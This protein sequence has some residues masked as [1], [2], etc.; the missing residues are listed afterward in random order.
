LRLALPNSCAAE[1]ARR[2]LVVLLLALAVLAL[3]DRAAARAQPVAVGGPGE[4]RLPCVSYAPFRREGHTPFNAALI[5]SPAQIEADLR[6]LRELTGCVRTYGIDHGLDQVPAIARRLGLRVVLGVWIGSDAAANAAQLDRALGL[7][8]E[9]ADV[10]DLLMVGNEVLLRRELSAQALGTLLADAKR[11]SSV[12]IGYADV[13]EFWLRHGAALRD[14]VDVVSVH[15]LPYWEDEPVAIG[16][17]VAHVQAILALVRK[18][19]QAQPVF[20]AE[21]GWP[22]DGRQRGAAVPGRLEQTRFVRDMLALDTRPAARGVPA[23]NLIEGFDQ[24]WKRSLEGAMGGHWGMFD[25][26][27]VQRV[28]LAGPVV[29]DPQA[30]E[31]LWAAGAGAA[32]ALLAWVVAQC[33]QRRDAAARAP[34]P[35]LRLLLSAL[36]AALAGAGIGALAVWQWRELE[37]WSRVPLEWARNGSMAALALAGAVAAAAQLSVRLGQAF[38]TPAPVRASLAAVGQGAAGRGVRGLAWLQLGLLFVVAWAALA[39]VFDGRYRPL[40]WPL[41]AAAAGL[42]LALALLGLRF[43]RSAREERLLAAVCGAAAPWLLLHEGLHN[44][45]ALALGGLWLALAWA[46]WWPHRRGPPAIADRTH[47]SADSSTA[48]AAMSAQ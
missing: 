27:G 45:E 3:L 6:V 17:A 4:S 32:V 14:H 18:A 10:V 44:T 31:R 34:Q 16:D 37:L 36:A 7:A 1:V 8:H 42:W 40:L 28:L 26:Q 30:R 41:L 13:W 11:R 24:P 33:R 43:D 48:G 9:H 46:T 38:H 47:T 5:V 23:F 22:S 12:P 15:V 35:Q 2:L 21:T 29:P 19:F 39:L 25:A 20:L